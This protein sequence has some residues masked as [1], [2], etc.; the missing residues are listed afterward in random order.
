[1][2]M[3]EHIRLKNTVQVYCFDQV[4]LYYML[5]SYCYMLFMIY[6]FFDIYLLTGQQ[7]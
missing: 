3:D 4:R 1:M 6:T 7:K 5:I 2:H